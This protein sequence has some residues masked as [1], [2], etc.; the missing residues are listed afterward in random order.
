MSKVSESAASA[1]L[2]LARRARTAETTAVLGFVIVNESLQL[3]PY[4]QSAL[5]LRDGG[6]LAVSGLPETDK[7]A[8]YVQWLNAL[9]AGFSD[10]SAPLV[11][12]A[13]TNSAGIAEE[14]LADWDDWFPPHVLALPL[15]QSDGKN[16][17]Y[18]LVA[19][20]Q[21][22]PEQDVAL[23]MELADVYAHAWR[24]FNRPPAWHKRVRDWLNVGKRRRNALIALVVVLLFP[25]RLTVMVPAEV[26]PKDAIAIRSP[27]E[28]AID[29]FH[30]RP[31]QQVAANQPLFDLDTT[32]LRTK[33]SVARKSFE[34]AAEEYRQAAQLAVSN[35]EKGRMEM[36]QRKGRME[37]KAAELSYSQEMLDR[38]QVKA[39]LAGVAVFSDTAD[40]IGKAVT[41]GER[42][43]QIADPKR[44]EITMRLPTTAAIPYDADAAVTL[45]LSNASQ[46]SYDAKLFYSSYRSEPGLDSVVSYKLKAAFVEGEALPRLG[47]T[48][49]ARIYGG[50]VPFVYYLL[51]RPIGAARQWVGI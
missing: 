23:A 48:G 16:L 24:V 6:V 18:W 15:N 8:P 12:D 29:T 5:W 10:S 43:M 17:G 14:L 49:T 40:W 32:G 31:N 39:P 11:I 21:P 41:V 7:D 27:I 26:T 4:R 46:F 45:Y 9:C 2:H 19:D 50:W 34:A 25:V 51:R 20:E 47:L 3:L 42:V 1:L 28:G 13:T 22:W 35:D 38:V 44:V 37:E 30:V 36:S 33:L